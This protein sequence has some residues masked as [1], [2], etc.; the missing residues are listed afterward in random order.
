MP[1]ASWEQICGEVEINFS[2]IT[3]SEMTTTVPDASSAGFQCIFAGNTNTQTG[4]NSITQLSKFLEIKVAS[5]SNRSSCKSIS[6]DPD[7]PCGAALCHSEL[8]WLF[9]DTKE[10]GEQRTADLVPF[11]RSREGRR[12]RWRILLIAAMNSN[13]RQSLDPF[14]FSFFVCV[15]CLFWCRSSACYTTTAQ[16]CSAR[17]LF[18]Q[19]WREAGRKK[20]TT[21]S[22]PS[23]ERMS[24]IG[25][26]WIYV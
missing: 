25:L 23:G 26:D 22:Y 13:A 11:W 7:A 5:T 14:F 12:G 1:S 21:V 3:R 15:C 9:G 6:H 2:W 19:T 18:R 16:T 8:R 20:K 17:I 24:H 10:R 4:R